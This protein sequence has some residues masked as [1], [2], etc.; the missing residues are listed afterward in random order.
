M[1]MHSK[2]T[3]FSKFWFVFFILVTLTITLICVGFTYLWK[4]MVVY[5]Q[6]T[7]KHA[8]QNLEDVF[9]LE[10]YSVLSHNSQLIIN[11][12]ESDEIRSEVY[13]QNLN[14]GELNIG[15]LS[16]GSTSTQQ[17]YQVKAGDNII[18]GFTLIFVDEGMFGHWEVTQPTITQKMWGEVTVRLPATT[19]LSINGINAQQD[20]ITQADIPYDVL[21][22]LPESVEQPYLT[23]YHLTDLMAEP[24]LS[25]THE[26]GEKTIITLK[27]EA[28]WTLQEQDDTHNNFAKYYGEISL[29]QPT[30][31]IDELKEMAFEDAENYS[32]YISNDNSFSSLASRL[33]PNST[34]YSEM[35]Y[36]DTMFYTEHTRVSFED[37]TATNF[38]YY[39]D[40]IFS[41]DVSYTYTVYRGE[42]RPYVFDTNITFVYVRY[43][44]N[45]RIGDIRITSE[46][47]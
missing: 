7:P 20:L 43:N 32:L 14:G 15:R 47:E 18:G 6:S 10:Q 17:N 36:M 35:R 30:E 33:L 42:H 37:E 26:T 1:A 38:T 19:K 16:T 12:Y 11:P 25:I 5:E 21:E 2:K 28:M 41:V 39:S 3:S 23:E 27:T 24:T 45:W 22:R 40:D 8:M 46:S 29:P 34:I 44:D 13:S 31:D 9:A 4:V